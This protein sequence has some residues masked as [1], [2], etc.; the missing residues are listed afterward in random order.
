MFPNFC[1]ITPTSYLKGVQ[2][3]MKKIEINGNIGN[4]NSKSQQKVT[5]GT[6]IHK[7]TAMKKQ[8]EHDVVLKLQITCN[9]KKSTLYF[10]TEIYGKVVDVW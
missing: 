7:E 3:N 6:E 10:K 4:T 8:K 9:K 2:Q 5:E 1:Q